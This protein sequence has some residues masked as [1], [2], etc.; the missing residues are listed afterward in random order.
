VLPGLEKQVRIEINSDGERGN[1]PPSSSNGLYRVLVAGGSPAEC[2]LLDQPTSWPGALER[3]L[4]KPEN[5][6]VLKASKA[7][8]GNI[9]MSGIASAHLNLIFQKMLPQ[10]RHL[11]AI[12]VMVG[13]NDVWDWLKRRAPAIYTPSP[14][15]LGDVFSIYPGRPFGWKPRTS[16]LKELFQEIRRRLLHPVKVRHHSGRWIGKARAMRAHATEVLNSVSDPQDMLVN[17]ER[18][19]SELLNTA[20][21]HADRVLVVQQPW[22]EKNSYTPEEICHFWNGGAMGDPH[23]GDKVTV[24]YS[25]E[26]CSQL[27]RLMNLRAAKVAD[28]LAL[29]HLNLQTSLESNL[30]NFY[31]FIHFTPA[32]ATV[33]AESIAK[34]LLEPH[35]K[36]QGASIL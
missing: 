30:R 14:V 36:E 26:V 31:D 11:S 17:F 18:N 32:G 33:I 22:F 8:V 25:V 34:I 12:I 19:L 35:S 16:A 1:E 21:T 5:L 9:G 13:G 4:E 7:H 10:Y 28:A 6:R 29:E 3:V 15:R 2:G 23:M 27:M 24:F 20:K